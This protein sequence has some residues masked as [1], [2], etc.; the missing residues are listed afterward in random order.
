MQDPQG[1]SSASLP[2][3]EPSPSSPSQLSGSLSTPASQ[4]T[5]ALPAREEIF[6][7]TLSGARSPPLLP[8]LASDPNPR[9]LPLARSLPGYVAAEGGAAR[10]LQRLRALWEK[11][12]RSPDA[13]STPV[14]MGLNLPTVDAVG[15]RGGGDATLNGTHVANREVFR[16]TPERAAVLRALYF[17]E[18]AGRCDGGSDERRSEEHKGKSKAVD[19][20]GFLRYADEK[21][22]G[23][24]DVHPQDV[25][26]SSFCRVVEHLSQ[27]TGLRR[28][29]SSGCKRMGCSTSKVWHRAGSRDA[30][31]V[32]Y[33]PYFIRTLSHSFIPRISRFSSIDASQGFDRGDLSLL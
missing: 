15:E 19:W 28:E 5:E 25:H 6:V 2:P 10:R 30:E 17:K 11:L 13:Q 8:P 16:L 21:E 26:H 22:H 33:L 20:D 3:P 24:S 29:W 12:P 4:S 32:H 27:R 1:S 31:R 23:T 18:L 14:A 7:S 9:T